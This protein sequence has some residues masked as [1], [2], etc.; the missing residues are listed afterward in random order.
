M[1]LTTLANFYFYFYDVDYLGQFFLIIMIL[2][3]LAIFS[4]YY[5]F[6]YL[7]IFVST[8]SPCFFT[9]TCADILHLRDGEYFLT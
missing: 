3:T 8:P 2:T 1:I 4:Y 9:K 5:D 6:E 7:G